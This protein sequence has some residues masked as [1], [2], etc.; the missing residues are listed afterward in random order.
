MSSYTMFTLAEDGN[1]KYHV[2]NLT[3]LKTADEQVIKNMM[4]WYTCRKL[5]TWKQE[6]HRS[7]KHVQTINN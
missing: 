1:T 4:F 2:R 7:C 5:Q 3:H 6:V